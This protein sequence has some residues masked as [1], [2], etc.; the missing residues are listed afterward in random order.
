MR[1]SLVDVVSVVTAFTAAH[2]LTL[3]VAALGGV[4]LPS[5]LVESAIALTVVLGALNNLFPAVTERRWLA[6]FVFGLIHGYGFAS[7][8][9]DLGLERGNLALALAG[10][11]VG[12]ELG[13][14]AIVLM[15]APV[16][17]LLR[18]TF[19]YRRI[20]MPAGAV[21]IGVV[22]VYWLFQRAL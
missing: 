2:S 6:A 17:Y 10:F 3:S 19:L 15:L 14:L 5:R 9:T 20:I 11:N 22:G 4:N 7:V 13:Q 8:L 21:S 12:V 1:D 16:A 18:R